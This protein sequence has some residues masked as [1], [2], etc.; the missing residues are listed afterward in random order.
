MYLYFGKTIILVRKNIMTNLTDFIVSKFLFARPDNGKYIIEMYDNIVKIIHEVDMDSI[1][2]I[3]DAIKM[4]QNMKTEYKNS[5]QLLK[6]G[7][8]PNLYLVQS[9]EKLKSEINNTKKNM[10]TAIN[11]EPKRFRNMETAIKQKEKGIK[12]INKRLYHFT[13]KYPEIELSSSKYNEDKLNRNL[14][15]YQKEEKKMIK[16]KEKIENNEKM[17]GTL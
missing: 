13:S 16:L 4:V 3:D 10:K 14:E 9:I 17:K 2:D 12:R 15:H 7:M 8:L 11:I 5:L 6:S 1:Y